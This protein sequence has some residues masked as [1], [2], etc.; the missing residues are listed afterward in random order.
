M[1]FGNFFQRLK[2]K[3]VK[4]NFLLVTVF[5]IF[6][7]G[8]SSQNNAAAICANARSWNTSSSEVAQVL[9]NM[10]TTNAGKIQDVFENV[11]A[12]LIEI[13]SDS[14][15]ELK[16]DTEALLNTYGAL[17]DALQQLDFDGKVAEKDAGV[18]SA[19]VRLASNEVVN[20]QANLAN[21]I[22]EKCD[23]DIS[24]AINQFP[25]V[26][27]TLPDPL[28]Q[29]DQT[30]LPPVG[31]DD[32]NSVVRAFGYVVVERFGLAITDDQAVCVGQSLLEANA[33]DSKIVDQTYWE[34]LQSIFDSCEV[35]VDV[36]KALE[37]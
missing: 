26:G 35:N 8:C 24:N 9:E 37:G 28:I 20:A 15:R 23:L 31:Y 13:N 18:T 29:D 17:S 7:T 2:L 22:S 27:T 33:S 1:A 4:T 32:E 34:L 36:A 30:E 16:T 12:V 19:G 21:Y 11:V 10:T 14:P 5:V 25:N 6:I 3:N